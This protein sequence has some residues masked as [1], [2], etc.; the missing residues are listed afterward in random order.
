MRS[1]EGRVEDHGRRVGWPAGLR[2][3]VREGCRTV[4]GEAGFEAVPV[5]G[6]LMSGRL[7]AG[8]AGEEPVGR[9]RRTVLHRGAGLRS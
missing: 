2:A 3:G 5:R 8:W 4:P 1:E 7:T 6:V 9:L